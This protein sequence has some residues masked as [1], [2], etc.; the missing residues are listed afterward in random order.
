MKLENGDSKKDKTIFI[1]MIVA[2][3]LAVIAVAGIVTVI[4]VAVRMKNKG[5]AVSTSGNQPLNAPL[6]V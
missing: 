6:M 5:A 4:V 3:V 1:L 2:I